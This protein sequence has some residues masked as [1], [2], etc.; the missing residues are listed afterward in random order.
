MIYVWSGK[1]GSGKTYQMV[2]LAYQ[3]WK[4]GRDVYSNT[5]LR[6]EEANTGFFRAKNPGKIVYFQEISEI[7][8][9]KNGIILFDEAQVLFNARSWESLPLTFMYKL[10]QHRKHNLDLL[11]TTQNIG[12]IDISYRRLVQQWFYC[13][14]KFALFGKRNPSWLS[15]HYM[16]QKDIDQIYNTTDD[17]KV[18][19]LGHKIFLI[20]RWKTR[21]YDTLYDIGFKRFTSKWIQV[22][23]TNIES[24]MLWIYPKQMKLNDVFRLKTAYET[25]LGL[26]KP[27]QKK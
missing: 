15:V 23:K 7:Q 17:L 12:T 9:V 3:M 11:C 26:K 6:F 16:H 5:V 8:E 25:N 10:Q 21:L 24:K 14:D 19:N 27:Y 4:Q 22:N 13:E 20:H 1:T 2:K 18:D